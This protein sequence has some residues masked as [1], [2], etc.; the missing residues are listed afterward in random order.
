GD[1]LAHGFGRRVTEFVQRSAEAAADQ[2][3]DRAAEGGQSEVVPAEVVHRPVIFGDLDDPGRGVDSAFL[4]CFEERATQRHACHG[5]VRTPCQHAGDELSDGDAD[6]DLG[7][8]A[9]G[10]SGGGADAGPGGGDRGA[11][12]DGGDDHG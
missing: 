3:A 5:F 11:D 7:G 1:E 9:G 8:D 4:Q 2:A 6:G 10:D 12:F